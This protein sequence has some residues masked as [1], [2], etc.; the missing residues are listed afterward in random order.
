MTPFAA[1]I[2]VCQRCR[3]RRESLCMAA[4]PPQPFSPLAKGHSCP[5][6]LFPSRGLGDDVE[7]VLTATTVGPIAKRVIERVTGKPCRCG[8]RISWLNRKVPRNT[9]A[10][11]PA[12]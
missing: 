7:K 5:L 1:N 6:A 4:T 9:P 3:K 8:G 11:P 10:A 2:A 12:P